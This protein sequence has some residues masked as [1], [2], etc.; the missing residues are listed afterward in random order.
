MG[1]VKFN[2][3]ADGVKNKKLGTIIRIGAIIWSIQWWIAAAIGIFAGLFCIFSSNNLARRCKVTVD[4][5]VVRYEIDEPMVV[6]TK[7]GYKEYEMFQ[8]VFNFTLDGEEYTVKSKI[9]SETKPFE[10]GEQI[11]LKVNAD[12]PTETFAPGD[13]SLTKTGLGFLSFS[14]IVIALDAALLW[15]VFKKP[16]LSGSVKNG[17]YK[18]KV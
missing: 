13:K 17:K 4:A 16:K 9:S 14:F 15:K 5:T 10:E 11:V 8:P 6:E 12:D 2:F 3:K 7:N 18:F 1:N